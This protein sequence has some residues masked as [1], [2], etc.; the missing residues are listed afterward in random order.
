MGKQI[1]L[2]LL[3]SALSLVSCGSNLS[4][5][6]STETEISSHEE[7]SFSSVKIDSSS[8]SSEES[9]SSAPNKDLFFPTDVDDPMSSTG[10]DA[11]IG[12]SPYRMTHMYTGEGVEEKII[13][14]TY[15][16]KYC[17]ID[18]LG[19]I[20]GIK[21]GS[22]R[23]YAITESGKKYAIKI[24]V[25]PR[26][27]FRNWIRES[28]SQMLSNYESRGSKKGSY[29]FMGDSFFDPRGFWEESNFYSAF[30]GENVFLTGIGTAKTNDWM[31]IK[32]ENLIDFA[33][34]AIFMNLGVNNL[35]NAGDNGKTLAAKL[36]T[37]FE[38]LHYMKEDMPI[39]YYGIIKS[40][41][42][43]WND[44]SAIS[45]A[46]VKEYAETRPWLTYLDIPSELD[47]NISAYLKSDSLHPNDAAY[48]KYVEFAK[49]YMQ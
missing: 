2:L 37:L 14:Y 29:V 19:R 7:N 3:L 30:A 16:D 17:T 13:E 36:E 12:Y 43:S 46:L 45:N 28:A 5:A 27:S 20:T 6:S 38:E 42:Q 25:K 33:P 47:P 40:G 41:E 21:E 34:K 26:E 11:F 18:S 22:S 48:A 8:A 10:I 15:N 35:I 49:R 39:Y 32:K 44:K 9:S 4:P 1:N 24:N 31:T 23:A